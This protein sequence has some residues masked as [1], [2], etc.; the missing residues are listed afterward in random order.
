MARCWPLMILGHDQPI[1]V[2]LIGGD[3]QGQL[4][5]VSAEIDIASTGGCV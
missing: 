4:L 3:V 1:S 5:P 2:R